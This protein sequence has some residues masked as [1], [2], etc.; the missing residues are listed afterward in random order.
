MPQGHMTPIL[1]INRHLK[2]YLYAANSNSKELRRIENACGET[3]ND[4]DVIRGS[5]CNITED[6]SDTLS[7]MQVILCNFCR[8]VLLRSDNVRISCFFVN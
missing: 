3:K 8:L 2:S 5:I 6:Q 7:R 4:P 1:L